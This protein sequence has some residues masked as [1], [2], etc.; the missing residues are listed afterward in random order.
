ML[1][2]RGVSLIEQCTAGFIFCH[3]MHTMHGDSIANR[4]CLAGQLHTDELSFT[5]IMSQA[6]TWAPF[7]HG[8]LPEVIL[9]LSTTVHNFCRPLTDSHHWYSSGSSRK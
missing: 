2:H 5:Q 9:S 8:S 3:G 4:V 1:K 6:E 7:M